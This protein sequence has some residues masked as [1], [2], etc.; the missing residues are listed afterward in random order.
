LQILPASVSERVLRMTVMAMSNVV[1]SNVR[2]PDEP[3]Y[4][5]GAQLVLF[6]PVSIA[7]TG[8]GL[9]ITGFS[10]NGTLWVCF[11][12]CRQMI[13]DPQFFSQCLDEAFED[14]VTSAIARGS[15]KRAPAATLKAVS[16]KAARKQKA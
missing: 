1:V 16:S 5:A 11:V 12:S 3:M 9:N 4:M 8:I 2:G 13:P 10:Y 14:L 7:F 6:L 15:K